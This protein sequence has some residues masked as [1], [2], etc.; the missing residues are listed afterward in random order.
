MDNLTKLIAQNRNK[1][2]RLTEIYFLCSINCVK[3]GSDVNQRSAH[4]LG[5]VL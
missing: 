2:C 3:N 4:H 1:G 5:M